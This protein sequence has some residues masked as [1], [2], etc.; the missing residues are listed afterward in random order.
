M[1]SPRLKQRYRDEIAPELKDEL[2]L[3]NV[4][5]VPTLTKIVV[6]VG[7]G[8]ASQNRG[9]IEDVVNELSLI[10]GQRPKVNR[11]RKSIAGFKLRE[12]QAVGASVTLRG[13]RMWEFYDRLVAI[14]IP[15]VRDFRGLNPKSFDGRGNYT[16]GF[17]EQ[18]VFPE[19]DYDKVSNVRGMDITIVT[20]ATDDAGGRLLLEKLG[21][22]FRRPAATN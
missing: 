4:M 15:R 14:A 11:A 1:S 9:V 10:T 5:Q 22:P 18:L 7:M 21:F 8:E 12:G 3:E 20:S 16:F 2:D 6:N 19:I 17:T 13:D